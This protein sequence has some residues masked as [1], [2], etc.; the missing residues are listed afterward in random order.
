MK[1]RN[2]VALAV[3][4]I[5]ARFLPKETWINPR[6]IGL[7]YEITEKMLKDDVY[8]CTCPEPMF[9]SNS[10]VNMLR[11]CPRH[12]PYAISRDAWTLSPNATRHFKWRKLNA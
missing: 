4:A 5:I 12:G 7:S 8:K 9:G 6:Q 3:G 1:R 11:T 2:F 10:N